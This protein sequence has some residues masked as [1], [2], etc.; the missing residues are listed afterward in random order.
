MIIQIFTKD[1]KTYRISNIKEDKGCPYSLGEYSLKIFLTN[2]CNI[3]YH[4]NTDELTFPHIDSTNVKFLYLV[5]PLTF[6][7][8][9]QEDAVILPYKNILNIVFKDK[10]GEDLYRYIFSKNHD[11]EE[12]DE[13]PFYPPHPSAPDLIGALRD[14][15]VVGHIVFSEEVFG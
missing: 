3:Y 8:N 14:K 10:I 9:Y 6:Q 5:S 11:G 1:G 2:P 7:F 4:Y 13:P 12:I 15:R